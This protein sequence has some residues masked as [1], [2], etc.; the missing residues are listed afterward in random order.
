M[1]DLSPYQPNLIPPNPTGHAGQGH[2][3]ASPHGPRPRRVRLRHGRTCTFYWMVGSVDGRIELAL[4]SITAS[5]ISSINLT[6]H[7]P[8]PTTHNPNHRSSRPARHTRRC[9]SRAT[10]P[11]WPASARARPA[12]AATTRPTNKR[13]GGRTEEGAVRSGLAVG[14]GVLYRG[15]GARGS[16]SRRVGGGIPWRAGFSRSAE[17]V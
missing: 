12:R 5:L 2:H 7:N 13:L 16:R 14:S 15:S 17:P 4:P 9:A 8:P 11:S 1:D 6:D 10:T 3:H